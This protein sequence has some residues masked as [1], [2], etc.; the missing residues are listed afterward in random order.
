MNYHRLLHLYLFTSFTS[1]IAAPLC[2]FTDPLELQ[3]GVFCNNYTV[4]QS[5]FSQEFQDF[6]LMLLHPDPHRRTPTPQHTEAASHMC[7]PVARLFQK[8][9]RLFG[10]VCAN[11]GRIS[12]IENMTAS[13]TQAVLLQVRSGCD[14]ELLIVLTSGSCARACLQFAVRLQSKTSRR[15]AAGA[16]GMQRNGHGK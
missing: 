14:I 11:E 16:V 3:R 5:C 9:Q 15:R 6:I 13:P 12:I 4:F 2:S 1:L 10:P 8:F 7:P